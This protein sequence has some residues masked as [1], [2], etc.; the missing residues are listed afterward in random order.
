MHG[1][2][3]A[4]PSK[5]DA[6]GGAVKFNGPDYDH[7]RDSERLGKQLERVR[8]LMSDRQWRSL[9]QIAEATG[10]PPSSVS[11]Q[12][13]HLRKQRFGSFVIEKLSRGR[14][15]YFYRMLPPQAFTLRE[16]TCPQCKGTGHVAERVYE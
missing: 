13:R 11:A 5:E 6:G 15:L 8:D 7:R 4:V 14:G 2:V 10:D 12:L 16:K 1:G 9:A 3:G